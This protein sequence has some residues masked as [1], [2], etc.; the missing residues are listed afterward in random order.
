MT[1]LKVSG[2]GSFEVMEESVSDI[3]GYYRFKD[4][5]PG[6]YVIRIGVAEG[7]VLTNV[8]GAPLGEIDSDFDPETA[9]TD[10]ISLMSGQTLRNIDAGFVEK[11]D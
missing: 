8:F 1:L 9:Q 5:R 4:L 2:D 6:A 10:V 11:A 3:Y 7:D